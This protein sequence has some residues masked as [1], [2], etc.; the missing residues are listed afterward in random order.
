MASLDAY[1]LQTPS[2]VEDGMFDCKTCPRAFVNF[3]SKFCILK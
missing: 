3:N 1:K 2:R